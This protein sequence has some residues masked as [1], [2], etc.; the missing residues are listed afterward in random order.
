MPAAS[1]SC[2]TCHYGDEKPTPARWIHHLLFQTSRE[3][4][5]ER[6]F[7]FPS[8]LFRREGQRIPMQIHLR[9]L[10]F[11]DDGAVTATASRSFTA[12]KGTRRHLT[13]LPKGQ[14]RPSPF[15]SSPHIR[16]TYLIIASPNHF[17][18]RQKKHL[19][20]TRGQQNTAT[21]HKMNPEDAAR[22]R[23]RAGRRGTTIPESALLRKQHT[24]TF[25]SIQLTRASSIQ[26]WQRGPLRT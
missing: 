26:N 6:D 5:S 14:V 20:Y 22:S 9:V 8:K 11:S 15:P 2:G 13:R 25:H 7:L 12:P 1:T 10:H 16:S 17:L 18:P 21:G 23:N 19:L 24:S 3:K 4:K